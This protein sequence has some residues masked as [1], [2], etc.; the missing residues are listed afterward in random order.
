M[1]VTLATEKKSHRFTIVFWMKLDNSVELMDVV[2]LGE[3]DKKKQSVLKAVINAAG[4]YKSYTF[5]QLGNEIK[6]K[7]QLGMN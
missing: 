5:E 7:V 6:A 1:T 2:D 4:M 3:E